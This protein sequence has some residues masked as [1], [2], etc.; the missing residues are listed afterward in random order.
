[1]RWSYSLDTASYYDEY[2]HSD[3]E[4]VDHPL[5]LNIGRIEGGD[6]ASSVPA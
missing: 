5:N 6:W 1:M 3:H 4:H 2:K